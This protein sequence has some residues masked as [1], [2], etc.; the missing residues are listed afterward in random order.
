[1]NIYHE[2]RGESIE[3]Q[4]AVAAITMNRV[5]SKDYGNSVCDVV[6]SPYQ[7]SW[8][9]N[10]K[11]EVEDKESFLKAKEIAKSYLKGKKNNKVGNRLFFNNKNIGKRYKVKNK[12]IVLGKLIFY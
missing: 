1:M 6:Y 12:P 10:R 4:E 8:T 5:K 3:T 7:F 9:K 11:R 2:S